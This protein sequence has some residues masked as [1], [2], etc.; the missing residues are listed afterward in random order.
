MKVKKTY[1][2]DGKGFNSPDESARTDKIGAFCY[3]NAT[4]TP[5]TNL[6]PN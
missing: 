3:Q 1:L 4:K 5:A 2:A 6:L